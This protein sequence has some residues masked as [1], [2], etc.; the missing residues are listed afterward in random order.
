MAT[1]TALE[2]TADVFIPRREGFLRLSPINKRRW[3]NFRGNGR[4][5][6]SLVIFLILFF[7]SLF[8]ELI[9]NDRPIL[10]SYK[11]ELLFPTF[12]DYPEAKFG[13][14]LARTNY[15]DPVNQDEIDSIQ[16]LLDDLA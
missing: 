3:R 13:G 12:T 5:Y 14:F 9:A 4:G 1:A 15:R 2:R 11:G 10:V 7:L 16:R 8:A 6:W